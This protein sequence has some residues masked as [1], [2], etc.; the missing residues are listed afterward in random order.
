MA[1]KAGAKR[2]FA[3]QERGEDRLGQRDSD[4]GTGIARSSDS[5]PACPAPWFQRLPGTGPGPAQVV[6]LH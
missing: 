2:S 3:R 4:R 6:S 5:L 1:Q